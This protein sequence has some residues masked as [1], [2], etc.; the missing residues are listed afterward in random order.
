MLHAGDLVGY[1][2]ML[3]LDSL[4]SIFLQLPTNYFITRFSVDMALRYVHHS[5]N[6]NGF[7]GMVVLCKEA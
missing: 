5:P 3:R 6:S 7:A 1:L 4:F 2:L